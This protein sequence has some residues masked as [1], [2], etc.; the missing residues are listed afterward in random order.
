MCTSTALVG[1]W[2]L[3]RGSVVPLATALMLGCGRGPE[4]G[5]VEGMVRFGRTPLAGVEVRFLPDPEVG[6]DGPEASAYTDA[7][8][9]FRLR[10]PRTEQ[11]GAAAGT[12]RVCVADP[13][14]Q[15]A[16]RPA[17]PVP[18]AAPTTARPKTPRV[19]PRCS[20]PA[21]TPFR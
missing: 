13:A 17:A 11:A 1:R 18:F 10:T 16:G 7:Q 6:C 4:Y 9:R 3:R 15:F 5:E 20:D 8:G 19:P 14:S 21:T 12:Y 2:C